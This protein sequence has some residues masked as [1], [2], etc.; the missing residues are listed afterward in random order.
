MTDLTID[1]VSDFP[2]TKF[3]H[4]SKLTPWGSGECSQ[5]SAFDTGAEGYIVRF[6]QHLDD[7]RKDQIAARFAGPDLPIPTIIEIGRLCF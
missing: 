2:Q 4:V 5:A 6:G 3:P 1:A 7:Y